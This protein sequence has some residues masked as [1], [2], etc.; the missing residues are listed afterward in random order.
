MVLFVASTAPLLLASPAV[1][2]PHKDGAAGAPTEAPARADAFPAP[3]LRCRLPAL[4]VE[5]MHA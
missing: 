5:A 2:Y 3:R 4:A 1:V